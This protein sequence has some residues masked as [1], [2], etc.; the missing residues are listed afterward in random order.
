L[1]HYL[2]FPVAQEAI[3]AGKHVLVEKPLAINVA[4]GRQVVD[5]AATAGV[6]PGVSHNQVFYAAHAEAKRLIDT[7]AIGSPVLI[8]LRLGIASVLPGPA[9]DHRS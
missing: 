7:G 6:S 2:H 3:R 8:R 9:P 1:P 5:A 4:E